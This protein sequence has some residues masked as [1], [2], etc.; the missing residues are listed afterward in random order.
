MLEATLTLQPESATLEVG[1][2]NVEIDFEKNTEKEIGDWS[3]HYNNNYVVVT[4]GNRR[5]SLQWKEMCIGSGEMQWCLTVGP[6]VVTA[7]TPI[8]I[9]WIHFYVCSLGVAMTLG[10]FCGLPFYLESSNRLSWSQGNTLHYGQCLQSKNKYHR[11][12]LTRTALTLDDSIVV[13][14]EKCS[15]LKLQDGT[16]SLYDSGLKNIWSTSL[17]SAFVFRIDDSGDLMLSSHADNVVIK[18]IRSTLNTDQVLSPGECLHSPND[19]HKLCLYAN[20]LTYNDEIV[21]SEPNFAIK[22]SIMQSDGNFVIYNRDDKPIWSTGTDHTEFSSIGLDDSGNLNMYAPYLTKVV[23]LFKRQLMLGDSLKRGERLV[24]GDYSLVLEED[25]LVIYNKGEEYRVIYKGLPSL[26]TLV[27][28][29][30]GISVLD[31]QM[32]L[33]YNSGQNDFSTFKL[34]ENGQITMF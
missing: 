11:L 28:T 31:E 3:L 19:Q 21:V 2:T 20:K 5:R 15:F 30:A 12:C 8:S 9:P 25:R 4:Y 18:P 27:I 13:K 6:R 17:E 1:D 34:E 16:V 14:C 22:H 7:T 24:N 29:T 26:S 32:R 10:I 23:S 33:R